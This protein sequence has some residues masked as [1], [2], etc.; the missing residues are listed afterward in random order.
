MQLSLLLVAASDKP[1]LILSDLYISSDG[2]SIHVQSR[3][4]LGNFGR[5]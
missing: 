5:S 3:W 2:Y 4:F 1:A